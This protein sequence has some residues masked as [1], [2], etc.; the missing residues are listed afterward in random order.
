[1]LKF[2]LIFILILILLR[3]FGRLV[4]Y[5]NFHSGEKNF[6]EKKK[7]AYEE[8]KKQE[9]KISIQRSAEENKS[10]GGDFVDYEE[11]K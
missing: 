8:Q 9:G 5:T 11:L 3:M 7:A 6:R 10:R 1:M 4:I 2:L